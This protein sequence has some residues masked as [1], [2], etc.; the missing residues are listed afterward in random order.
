MIDKLTTQP[1]PPL[2]ASAAVHTRSVALTVGR[3]AAAATT[4]PLV[5][6]SPAG[7]SRAGERQREKDRPATR[8]ECVCA[9]Q[10]ASLPA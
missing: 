7:T 2:P 3:S 10:P 9:S 4:S 5:T 1:T 8:V 6:G